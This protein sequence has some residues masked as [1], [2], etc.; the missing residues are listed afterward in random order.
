MQTKKIV[1]CL[2]A[3]LKDSE[4]ADRWAYPQ[5]LQDPRGR[6]HPELVLCRARSQ[7]AHSV[8]TLLLSKRPHWP[9]MSWGRSLCFGSKTYPQC[10]QTSTPPSCRA[11]WEA[12][13]C[14]LWEQR[15]TPLLNTCS[16][17]MTL[18]LGPSR[19]TLTGLC[20]LVRVA[21]QVI[22]SSPALL[23]IRFVPHLFW[24]HLQRTHRA[25]LRQNI[26]TDDLLGKSKSEGKG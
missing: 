3:E 18:C 26:G 8:R 14:E 4:E 11:E 9:Q 1:P 2:N 22:R 15:H 13:M 17:S 19:M 12:Q 16:C 21:T 23:P 7:C 10:L 6:E 24:P 25:S 20:S 5:Q